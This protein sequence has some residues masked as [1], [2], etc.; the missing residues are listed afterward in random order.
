MGAKRMAKRYRGCVSRAQRGEDTGFN[1]SR[2][3]K[4]IEAFTL[5]FE[6]ERRHAVL[7]AGA[8]G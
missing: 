8:L 4:V 1:R 7:S 6:S 2:F 3:D 5:L